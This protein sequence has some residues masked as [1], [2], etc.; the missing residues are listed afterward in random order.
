M[1]THN[2]VMSQATLAAATRNWFSDTYAIS[3]KAMMDKVGVAMKLGVPA[4]ARTET[5]AYY[6][7]VP[8]LEYW[9]YGEPIPSK[10]FKSVSYSVSMKRFAR[11]IPW[12]EDDRKDDQTGSLEARV[13][14]LA[15]R[16]ALRHEKAFFDLLLGTT[17]YLPSVPNAPDG[18]AFFAATAG[19]ADR[20]QYSGGNIVS[21]DGVATPGAIITNYMECLT[22]ARSFKD[23][24]GEPLHDESLIDQ[25]ALV[26]AGVHNMEVIQKAFFGQV[27]QGSSAGISNIVRDSGSKF[28]LWQT[29]RITTD[30]IYVIFTGGSLRPTAHIELEAIQPDDGNRAN[31]DFAR[32]FG[33]EYFQVYARDGYVINQPYMAV[34][35]DN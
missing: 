33:A 3:A 18:A 20:F 14:T 32:D 34:K 16:A 11:R 26:I 2:P 5:M 25:G 12:N 30:D 8:T 19:G 15:E 17:N 27:I 23:T 6:E 9:P 31:S 22:A 21:G 7:S 28:T 10:G 29:A 24:E 4:K 1:P 13:R 35:I